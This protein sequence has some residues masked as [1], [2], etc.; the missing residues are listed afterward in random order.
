MKRWRVHI[1][2]SFP[3]AEA[4]DENPSFN[5]HLVGVEAHSAAAALPSS[6]RASVAWDRTI[7]ALSAHGAHLAS[8]AFF[9]R[10]VLKPGGV[11]PGTVVDLTVCVDPA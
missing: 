3:Y 7:E 6:W 2:A 11:D 4:M 10:H 5:R 9:E 8:L 1:E